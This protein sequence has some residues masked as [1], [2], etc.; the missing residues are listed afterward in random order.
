LRQLW[1]GPLIKL[2]GKNLTVTGPGTLDGQGDW[3][4]PQGQKVTRPVFFRLNKVV[5]STLSGFS[6]KNSPYRTFSILS[7]NYTTI[8]SLEL[9]SSAGDGLAKNTDGFDLGRNDHV[10]ITGCRVYN[11]DDCLAMQSSTN[12]VFSNNYCKGGHGVSIGSLGGAVLDS[13]N[14]LD[15][16]T[17]VN[18]TIVNNDNGL[19]IKTIIDFVGLV[20]NVNYINNRVENCKHAI[21]VHSDYNKTKGGYSGIPN[22]RVP[23]TNITIDGLSGTATNIYDIKANS[24]VVSNWEFKNIHVTGAHGNCTGQPSNI[25]C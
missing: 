19:R 14:T 12:T 2:T 1:D 21:V 18:N 16:L 23:I 13:S 3:Y 11:Q 5:G 22:S 7:S 4:W 25:E 6:I 17:V 9:N 10:T 15:G 24:D 20:A 8:S